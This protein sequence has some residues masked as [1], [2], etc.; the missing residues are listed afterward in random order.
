MMFATLTL[1][2]TVFDKLGDPAMWARDG[3]ASQRCRLEKKLKALG[4]HSRWP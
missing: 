1:H 4:D 2:D 3:V